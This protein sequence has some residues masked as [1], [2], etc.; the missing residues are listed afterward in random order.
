MSCQDL[1]KYLFLFLK[2]CYWISVPIIK[3]IIITIITIVII[4]KPPP[5]LSSNM[6][7]HLFAS[8]LFVYLCLSLCQ[9]VAVNL[10]FIGELSAQSCN[11][12]GKFIFLFIYI[13]I[14]SY[15]FFFLFTYIQFYLICLFV[16]QPQ[17][18]PV[19]SCCR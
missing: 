19:P 1:Y 7:L 8:S 12:I 6:N 18:Q 2:W 14:F 4:T 17:S 16:A 10:N 3:I 15:L 5:W 11:Q 9:V 13:Y